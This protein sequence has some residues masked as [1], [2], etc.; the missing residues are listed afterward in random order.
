MGN[1][2]DMICSVSELTNLFE[3]TTNLQDFL[4]KVVDVIYTHLE[5]DACSIFLTDKQ[6]EELILKATRGLNPEFVDKLRLKKGEGITGRAL[7]KMKPVIVPK[8][9]EDKRNKHIPGMKEEQYQ[10]VLAVPII[11]GLR[12]IGVIILHHKA[13]D[14]FSQSDARALLAIAGQLATVIESTKLLLELHGGRAGEDPIKQ[15]K[16]A[17]L[18]GKAPGKGIAFGEA[19]LFREGQDQAFSLP[20]ENYLESLPDLEESIQ[21]TAFQ[22][23]QIQEQ[24][25]SQLSDIGSLIFSSHLLMLKDDAF[26]GAMKALVQQGLQP[27]QAVYQVVNEYM[28]LFSQSENPSVREKVLDLKDLG[29]RLLKNL[30]AGHSEEGDYSGTIIIAGELLP[31]ELVKFSAQKAE[32]IILSGATVTSHIM[33]LSRSLSLPVVVLEES[34]DQ[35]SSGD[36]LIVDGYQGTVLINPEQEV[37]A[38]YRDLVS[39][40]ENL[41]VDGLNGLRYT[42]DGKQIILAA[43]INL[44]SDLSPCKKGK[45]RGYWALSI[46]VSLHCKENYSQR[47][48]TVQGL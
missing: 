18:R 12:H 39:N 34:F 1:Q 31:S 38:N 43:N 29:H 13:L 47:R 45:G 32:G 41:Q 8:A 35:I 7:S 19:L 24:M 42:L 37:L 30:V 10:S 33:I 14:G 16:A 36:Q 25:D 22:L 17:M 46:G 2:L 4:M 20:E 26:S 6:S 15:E 40:T 44:L 5:S 27:Q 21:K 9:W 11:S 48:R 23:E 3:S 28:Q